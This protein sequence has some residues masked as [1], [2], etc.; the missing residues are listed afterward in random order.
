[1]FDESFLVEQKLDMKK[2]F[3]LVDCRKNFKEFKVGI[4]N[5]S[6]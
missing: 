5:I 3:V 4:G 6:K 2:V 1:M